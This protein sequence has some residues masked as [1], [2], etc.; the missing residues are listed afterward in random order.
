MWYLQLIFQPSQKI[1][2]DPSGSKIRKKFSIADSQES[3]AIVAQ[4][5]EEFETK[6]KLLQLQ[7]SNIQPKLLIVKDF[8][9]IKHISIYLDNIR[10]PF[11]NILNA[12]DILFKLFFV[13]NLKYPEESE[14]FYHFI[15]TFLYE[16]P[17]EKKKKIFKNSY[18]KA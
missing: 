3:F 2:T 6:I 13:F 11:R 15:Q 18:Y 9:Q 16:I 10:Y 4:T 8:I 17:S 7:H 12:F 14:L 5:K 1:N